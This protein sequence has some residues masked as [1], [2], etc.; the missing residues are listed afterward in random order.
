VLSKEDLALHK[1]LMKLLNEASYELKAREISAF[2]SI[3]NWALNLP[4]LKCEKC[5]KK[6]KGK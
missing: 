5:K 4:D 1:G 6:K 2:S 3:Y